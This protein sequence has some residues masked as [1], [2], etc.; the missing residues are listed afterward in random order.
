MPAAVAEGLPEV[1]WEVC[2]GEEAGHLKG[3][4]ELE[5]PLDQGHPV[6]S[7]KVF[8]LSKR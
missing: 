5:V 3:D 4:D 8:A 7:K 2:V 6:E 1:D